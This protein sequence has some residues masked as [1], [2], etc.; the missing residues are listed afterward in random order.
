MDKEDVYLHWNSMSRLQQRLF[1]AFLVAFEAILGLLYQK[2]I[3]NLI[4]L[5]VSSSLPPEGTI[6]PDFNWLLQTFQLI[7]VGF[8]MVKIL[9]DDI[10]PSRTRTFLM[11]IS[12]LL[13]LVHV[14]F[15]L[16]ILLYGLGREANVTFGSGQLTIS[17]LTWSSTY[18]A[19]AVG[20][21]LTYSV[22]RYGN[23]AQS[24][25]FM[26][27][28]YVGIAFMWTDWLFPITEAPADGTLVWSLFF[29]VLIGSFLLTGLAGIIID[30]L[31]F[32]G[33][34]VSKS[35]PDVMMIASLGVAM[36]LRSLVYL[37]FGSN[38]KRFVPDKDWMDSEQNWELPSYSMEFNLGIS[39]WPIIEYGTTNYA[40]N[41]AFLPVIVFIGVFLL[42]LLLNYTRL[43]RR[44]RAVADN[45][46][47]AAS[48]GI[49]VERVQMTSAFLSAGISGLGGAIF[50][51]TVLF[52][53]QTAFT[54]LLPASSYIIVKFSFDRCFLNFLTFFVC[55][56]SSPFIFRGRPR[57]IIS[58]SFLKT[59]FFISIIKSF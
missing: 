12:P 4:D 27:G 44:M 46:D 59:I 6:P 38:S 10:K 30:R 21:T 11:C 39:E 20:C 45:P 29:Y 15:S 33:F 3:L 57:T 54:L 43:G 48:S 19:I 25:F 9:F 35:S 24:E 49:N 28:M 17:T 7:C 58:I 18:L 51:L 55:V 32:K 52:S 50:G 13:L 40:Y 22:Q 56:E 34:R 14:L 2:G 41:N 47:L 26:L 23:F 36:I 31:V 37:R 8:F 53:P 42:V 16:H 5:F 1:I